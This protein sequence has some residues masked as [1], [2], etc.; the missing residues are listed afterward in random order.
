[1]NRRDWL[2]I[3]GCGAAGLG[4]AS[5][6]GQ[7][8]AEGGRIPPYASDALGLIAGTVRNELKADVPGTLAGIRALGYRYW[9]GGP[10]PGM[11]A[12]EFGAA[13]RQAG[14][15]SL[16]LGTAMGE[17]LNDTDRFVRDAGALE[18]PY[19]VCYWPWTSSAD[20]ITRA[21]T[22]EAARRLNTLGATCRKAGLRLVWHNHDKEFVR[23]DGNLVF[24]VLMRETD[25]ELVGV[26]LDWYWVVKGGEDPVA[27]FRRFPGRFDLGHVKDMN[28]H[29]DR[30]ITCV[31]SGIIDFER[32]I[33]EAAAGGTR[34][35]IVE[36]E[37]AVDGIRCARTSFQ[38]LKTILG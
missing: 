6:R 29:D 33:A 30:G 22:L 1:M 31:G 20:A 9:E 19:V 13:L 23:I 32:I 4:L 17:L 11:T 24:D 18:A 16:G 37:R 8:V 15:T 2:K 10:P 27:L 3:M 21:E 25:P 26:E 7:G 5:A 38:H 14:L 28:N 35:L 34:H 12:G 36:N